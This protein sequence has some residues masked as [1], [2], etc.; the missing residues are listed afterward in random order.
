MNSQRYK[1]LILADRRQYAPGAPPNARLLALD[2]QNP[3]TIYA[4][5]PILFAITLDLSAP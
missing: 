3:N 5:G 4:G 2:S 1:G